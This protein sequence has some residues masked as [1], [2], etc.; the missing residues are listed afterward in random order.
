M[1]AVTI[2]T[3][4]GAQRLPVTDVTWTSE[5]PTNPHVVAVQAD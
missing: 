1:V 5:S 3:N 4:E 2:D